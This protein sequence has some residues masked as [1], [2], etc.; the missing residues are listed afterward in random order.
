MFAIIETGGKQ[1]RVEEGF[2]FNVESLKVEPG[3]A[4]TLDKVL[5]VGD[6]AASKVGAPYVEGAKVDCEV[7]GH[8]RGP[9]ILVFHKRPKK[10]SRK[11]Q[12]HRQNFTRLKV[13]AITA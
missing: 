2:E 9:K 5:L 10:D 13:K 3:A 7:L 1:F 11:T 8:G 6:G 12:G 4:L